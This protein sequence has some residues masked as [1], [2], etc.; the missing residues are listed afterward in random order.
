[1]WLIHCEGEVGG[2][3]QWS[4]KDRPIWYNIGASVAFTAR[5]RCSWGGVTSGKLADLVFAKWKIHV[6]L[7]KMEPFH[8]PKVICYG[9]FF[10]NFLAV[11]GAGRLVE[12]E[13][14]GGGR[15]K[16]Q[17]DGREP[18]GKW[19]GLGLITVYL[20]GENHLSCS[21]VH[22]QATQF[23]LT[24]PKLNWLAGRLMPLTLWTYHRKD[25]WNR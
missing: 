23:Y 19:N 2:G 7:R 11:N 21:T 13:W 25:N 16:T 4:L 14:N 17:E 5:R 24:W 6:F 3:H 15:I 1:M 20:D 10:N 22:I 8:L 12:D 9:K 18:T